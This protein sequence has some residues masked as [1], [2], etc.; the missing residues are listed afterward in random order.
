MF[1]RACFSPKIYIGIQVYTC[2]RNSMAAVQKE[3][4]LIFEFN[5]NQKKHT[6]KIPA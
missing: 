3:K 2:T 4:I 6:K 1:G 5:S